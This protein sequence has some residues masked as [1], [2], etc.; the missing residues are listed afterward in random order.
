MVEPTPKQLQEMK[1]CEL[2]IL[3]AFLE[4]CDRLSLHYYLLGG[5][6]LGAVR[7]QG[8]IPWDDDIDVGMPREDYEIFLRDG[9]KYLPEY[10]FLQ[11]LHSEPDYHLNFAKIR[12]SRTTFVEYSVRR[13]KINHG[14]FIDIFPL[15][16]YPAEEKARAA[17]D[18]HQQQ[19]KYRLR[20]EVEIP[21][22]SRHGAV[23]EMGLKVLSGLTKLRYPNYRKALERREILQSTASGGDCWANYCGAWGKKEIVPAC[24]YGQGREL[25]FEGLTVTG[26][27]HYEKWLT[28][29][30]GDYM[31]LPPEEKRVGHHYAEIIDL[32]MPYTHYMENNLI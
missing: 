24:W 16:I 23:A 4:V 25:T 30:Y 28:Q 19:F 14:I 12:D 10:Y 6:L 3:K 31:Q 17:M 13:R 32:D 21:E 9:Q 22:M 2:N 1:S 26:P 5:T 20:A 7:H 11:S 18:R 27:E 29:V 15:D 8:F